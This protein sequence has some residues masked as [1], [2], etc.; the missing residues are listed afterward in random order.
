MFSIA[1]DIIELLTKV[2][3]C[4]RVLERETVCGGDG[5]LP[6]MCRSR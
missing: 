1:I 2:C 3:V 4:V 6:Q 5:H